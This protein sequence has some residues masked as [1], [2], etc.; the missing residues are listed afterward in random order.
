MRRNVLEQEKWAIVLLVYRS[1]LSAGKNEVLAG[2]GCGQ[3]MP[4]KAQYGPFRQKLD[5]A[6]NNMCIKYKGVQARMEPG[7]EIFKVDNIDSDSDSEEE[8]E[9]NLQCH[10][11]CANYKNRCEF[12][13]RCK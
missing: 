5:K 3:R 12:P 1:L 6:T 2:A 9:S 8:D 13:V 11:S 10:E 4:Q 7:E